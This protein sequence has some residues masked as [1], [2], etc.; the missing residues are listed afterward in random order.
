MVLDG[1][2]RV[3]FRVLRLLALA[4]LIVAPAAYLSIA[5]LVAPSARVDSRIGDIVFF[6]L[7]V[8]AMATPATIYPI[9]RLHL[10]SWRNQTAD[11]QT[12]VQVYTSLSII[13]FALT[14]A[15][16]LFGL[17]VFFLT[18]SIERMLWLCLVGAIW[19]VVHWPRRERFEKFVT[20]GASG[21]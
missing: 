8:V 5:Y 2:A 13:K 3:Q 7:L 18:G 9:A 1:K 14:E 4:I 6:M 19:T 11:R 17:V 20:E 15:A 16:H 10:A 21:I 12:P